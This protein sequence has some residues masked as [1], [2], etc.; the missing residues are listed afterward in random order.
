MIFNNLFMRPIPTISIMLFL[1]PT[2]KYKSIRAIIILLNG[3]LFHGILHDNLNM[4]FF[5]YFINCIISLYT[6]YYHPKIINLGIKFAG[7]STL[8]MLLWHYNYNKSRFFCDIL[9]ACFCHI[10]GV[11]FLISHLKHLSLS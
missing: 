5:D 3:I 9:H 7:L 4:L 11:L 1:Y 10:P 8:N 6:F 2:Y